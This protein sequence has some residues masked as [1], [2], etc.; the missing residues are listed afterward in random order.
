MYDSFSLKH[1][2]KTRL[3][4]TY[5]RLDYIQNY[6]GVAGRYKAGQTQ[7]KCGCIPNINLLNDC[8]SYAHNVFYLFFQKVPFTSEKY[9][10]TNF[11][12]KQ[13]VK[14]SSIWEK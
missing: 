6:S 5:T 8:K 7:R 10:V 1:L 13:E 11:Y 14:M 12:T 3:F 2:V 9:I 4:Y